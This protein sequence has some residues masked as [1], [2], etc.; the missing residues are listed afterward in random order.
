M[1]QV[2]AIERGYMLAQLQVFPQLHSLLSFIGQFL[3]VSLQFGLPH[4]GGWFEQPQCVRYHNERCARVSR[5]RE[6]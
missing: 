5:D 4:L 3:L 2:K 6:P 1:L